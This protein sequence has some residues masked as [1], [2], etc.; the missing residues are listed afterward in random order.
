[1]AAV[2]VGWTL[3]PAL[4][5]PAAAILTHSGR[6][7]TGWAAMSPFWG[8][9]AD[10]CPGGWQLLC[11]C[12]TPVG[13]LANLGWCKGWHFFP[14][15]AV[16]ALGL[17]AGGG[18]PCI[19]LH[20][21]WL[22]PP[23]F[24]GPV[25]HTVSATASENPSLRADRVPCPSAGGGEG[26]G[27]LCARQMVVC[28]SCPAELSGLRG[29]PAAQAAR[30]LAN[31]APHP[32]SLGQCSR[33]S[34]S[35]PASSSRSSGPVSSG[36]VV[37]WQMLWLLFLTL[38]GPGGFVPMSL[39]PNLGRE[40]HGTVGVHDAPPGRWPWQAS[41]RRHSKEREQW[42]HVCGG[43]LVHLQWVLTAAHCTGRESRQASAFRVQV[44]QLR[45]Y[46]PDRLMKV[47]EIIPHP[48]YNHLLSAKGGADIA[49]LRL[50]APVTLSPHVQVVSLPPASLRVPEKKMC[51]VTGWGDVRLGEQT[52]VHNPDKR[53]R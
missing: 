4:P 14:T 28:S 33:T 46:D 22:H 30:S 35:K 38:P 15:R 48:D 29:C 11:G 8:A 47:T 26:G 5:C 16:H 27:Q 7:W 40:Q 32:A 23:A 13:P 52:C 45:L 1:M 39:D 18:Q 20:P 3:S 37:G 53:R 25:G 9:L 17:L 19:T 50:E 34:S 6:C 2:A 10:Q 43:F 31:A 41:L 49:L 21:A 24:H 36:L 12:L 51:W 44:G 42:E